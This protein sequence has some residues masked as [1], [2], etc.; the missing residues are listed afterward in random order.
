MNGEAASRDNAE[1]ALERTYLSHE[2]TLMAWVRTATSM[3]AFGFT[4]YKFFEFEEQD[5]GTSSLERF[6]PRG[7]A[8][9]IVS[10]GMLSLFIA[11]LQH[12]Q[13]L[14]RLKAQMPTQPFPLA[15]VVAGLISFFG[16]AVLLSAILQF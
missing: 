16:V 9:F 2:R 8:I 1:L 6:T 13:Q 14:R 5:L 4:V 11:V 15:E 10:I 7:F 3:I 12:H